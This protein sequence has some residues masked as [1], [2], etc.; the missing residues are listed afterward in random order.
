MHKEVGG[1]V[2]FRGDQLEN[3]ASEIG[4]INYEMLTRMGQRLRRDYGKP[5]KSEA[6]AK[7]KGHFQSGK[8]KQQASVK[9]GFKKKGY[10]K[11]GSS[12]PR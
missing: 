9:G 8:P 4:T 2:V 1:V 10:S 6:S 5:E 7:P 11:G 3:E 12:N